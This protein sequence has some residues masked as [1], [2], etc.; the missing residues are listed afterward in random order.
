MSSFAIA[1]DKKINVLRTVEIPECEKSLEEYTKQYHHY[2]AGVTRYTEELE[3]RKAKGQTCQGVLS[4]LTVNKNM[5]ANYEELVFGEQTE[6]HEKRKEVQRLRN[7]EETA[8]AFASGCHARLGEKSIIN[9]LDAELI[10]III[11]TWI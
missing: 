7:A 10:C 4:H 6:I 1:V 3:D 8:L 5:A 2:E 11:K 9:T